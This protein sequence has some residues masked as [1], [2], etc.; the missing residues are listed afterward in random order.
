MRDSSL[1]TLPLR[2]NRLVDVSMAVVG[3]SPVHISISGFK[4][5]RLSILSTSSFNCPSTNF[6]INL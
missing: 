3:A 4:S 5:F 1:V 2:S 6:H